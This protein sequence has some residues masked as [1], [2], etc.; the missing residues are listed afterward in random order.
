MKI[1]NKNENSEYAYKGKIVS[2]IFI[3]NKVNYLIDSCLII[4]FDK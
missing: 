4:L 2:I 3:F 1:I